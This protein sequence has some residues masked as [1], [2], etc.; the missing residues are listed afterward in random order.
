MTSHEN[1]EHEQKMTL[2]RTGPI[3]NNAKS[4]RKNAKFPLKSGGIACIFATQI[5]SG[6]STRKTE[7]AT[8][9]RKTEVKS[10]QAAAIFSTYCRLF[11]FYRPNNLKTWK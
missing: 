9:L 3:S 6:G 1:K 8:S 5:T 7:F 2:S 4:F 11:G 10:D